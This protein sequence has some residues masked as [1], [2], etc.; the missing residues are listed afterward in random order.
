M[1]SEDNRILERISRLE[2]KQDLTDKK[3]DKFDSTTELLFKM[4]VILEQQVIS[5]NKQSEQIEKMDETFN[6]INENLVILNSSNK[7]MKSD[8]VEL[9]DEV[10]VLKS[11]ITKEKDKDK[12]SVTEIVKKY[13]MW[14]VLLP[15][16]FIGAWLMSYFKLK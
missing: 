6:R 13:I 14:W 2:V 3:L 16:T 4:S 9:K 5:N 7:S 15:M 10:S 8:F 12:F 1:S 11:D